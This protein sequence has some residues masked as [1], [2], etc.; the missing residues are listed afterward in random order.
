MKKRVMRNK[1]GHIILPFLFLFAVI[2]MPL[3][4]HAEPTENCTGDCPHE[5][6][7]GNMHY[8]TLVDAVDE[9]KDGDTIELLK[10]VVLSKLSGNRTGDSSTSDTDGILRFD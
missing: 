6:K 4:V 2:F 3:T 1:I 8:D 9:A 10:D 5:A 7:I